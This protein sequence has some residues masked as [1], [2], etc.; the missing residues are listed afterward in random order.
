MKPCA[1]CGHTDTCA[2]STP[3]G[4]EKEAEGKI[5]INGAIS[6]FDDIDAD[7]A[8]VEK[9]E[10]YEHKYNFRYEEADGAEVCILSLPSLLFP[11]PPSLPFSFPRWVDLCPPPF[12]L[13]HESSFV[14]SQSVANVSDGSYGFG[15][16]FV[17]TRVSS[18]WFLWR[19]WV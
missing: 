11:L 18:W 5:G 6:L 10:E 1:T 8:H 13:L 7:E 15:H 3:A 9:Q 12:T 16:G 2:V 14:L 17:H 19:Y 4:P